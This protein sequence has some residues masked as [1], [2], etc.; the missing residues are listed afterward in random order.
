MH[1]GPSLQDFLARERAAITEACTACGRCVEVCPVVPH[2]GIEGSEPSGVAA[3]VRAL[4]AGADQL[5]PDA[6]A[7]VG[8]CN[9]CGDCLPVC[10]EGV[11]PRRMVSLAQATTSAAGNGVPEV[12]RKMARAVR[13]MAAMQLVPEDV[14]RLLRHRPVRRAPVL[15]YLG[16]NAI[17]TPNVLLDA[18]TVLDALEVDYEVAGGPAACCGI[19]HTRT[20]GSIAAG[21]QVLATT[22]DRFERF[23]AERVLS[24]CP[25]CQLQIGETLKGFRRTPFELDHVTAFLVEHAAGLRERWTTPVPRR[26][27]LHAHD[28]FGDFGR[29]VETL[30]D[31]IPGLERVDTIVEA[32]Y[33]CGAAGSD[34]APA[35]KARD[36]ARL[37]E[38][39]RA[40]GVD[41]V[42]SLYHGCH[43][44]LIADGLRE[45]FDVVNFTAL[46]VEALGETP[47]HDGFRA[48]R[49]QDPD[50][51]VEAAGRYLAANGAAVDPSWLRDNLEAL[52]T[53]AEFRGGL[54]SFGRCPSA[55]R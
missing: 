4:L 54:E 38:R 9:G 23:H 2:A 8:H 40:S 13:L 12:F 5:T 53:Q 46:L 34:R 36:R 44:S 18:M 25:S 39:V 28:G 20:E 22:L 24:W 52:F 1:T 50:S 17:R 14:A 37:F 6:A 41:T 21:G 11:N 48:M 16:C 43:R 55:P 35:L 42:V 19:V 49:A 51:V 15:F 30:L 10:P 47:H 26:V 27:V 3:G 45:G 7:W 29:N 31:S 33:T 32:G